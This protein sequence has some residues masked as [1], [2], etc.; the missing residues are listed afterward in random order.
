MT[1]APGTKLAHYEIVEPIG[2]GGMGEVYRAKD[3]KLGRDVAIKVLPDEFAQDE[4][5]LRRFE[6]E[7]K[8][9]ASLNHSNIASIY[10]VEQSAETHYLVLELVPGE[11]LRER[12]AR[13]PIPLDEALPLFVQT[14]EGLDAAHEKGIVHRDLKPANII[15]TPEGQIKILDFGLAKAFANEDDVSAGTSQSQSPTLTRGTAMGVIL[16]TASYMSPEQAKGKAVDKRTDI[17]AFGCVVYE[18]L[19]GTKAFPGEDASEALAAVIRAAPDFDALSPKTPSGIRRMLRRCLTKNR[20]DRLADISDARI[21]I[22][23]AETEDV[24]QAFVPA[25]WQQPSW[26]LLAGA[27]LVTLTA[28]VVRN[29]TTMPPTDTSLTRYVVSLPETDILNIHTGGLAVSPDG[30]RL[31]Y[32]ATRNG[33]K[34]LFL[35]ERGSVDARPLPGTEGARTPVFSPD[36]EWLAFFDDRSL[37]KVSMSG[38]APQRI[39]DGRYPFAGTWGADDDIVF[40]TQGA[41]LQSVPASGGDPTPLPNIRAQFPLFLPDGE[42]LLV[43]SADTSELVGVYDLESGETRELIDGAEP[44][45][46]GDYLVVRR[47]DSLWAAPFDASRARV[48]GPAVPVVEGIQ[49]HSARG[50]TYGVAADGSLTFVPRTREPFMAIVDPGGGQSELVPIPHPHSVRLS[51]DKGRVAGDNFEGE[52]WVYELDTGA[53]LQV[54]TGCCPTWSHDGTK[55][56]YTLANTGRE[57]RADIAIKASDGTGAERVLLAD[58]GINWPS[59]WSPDGEWLAVEH[60]DDNDSSFDVWMVAPSGESREF[61]ATPANEGQAAFSPDGRWVA[62]RSDQSGRFEVYVEPFSGPGERV[63]VSVR[64]GTAPLWSHDG[65]ELYFRQDTAVMAVAVDATDEFSVGTPRHVVD[66]HYWLD[67]TGHIAF[68][69]FP[70][71]KLLMVDTGQANEIHVVLNWVE[72]LKRLVPSGN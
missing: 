17:W 11:T 4:E 25:S 15:V 58:E 33:T 27:L 53:R 2:K 50:A 39:S 59:S 60:R 14:A 20:R 9:L 56:A 18:S 30:R 61:L 40:A 1:L 24:Q 37:L 16:G 35:R 36:G 10:G 43:S 63:I 68:G 45:F 31:A 26:M 69:V 55:V 38:G 5:R 23:G 19:T 47:E 42:S 67:P 46:I 62:Y 22:E 70:D 49:S 51:P 3:S 44:R 13:G 6:R 29:L 12:I 34:Q 21:E 8:V 54:A 66:G 41:N 64:G 57:D 28:L 71:G 32:V 72:E 65:G 7:A 52:I 48:T